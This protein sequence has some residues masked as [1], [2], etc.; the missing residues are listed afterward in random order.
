MPSYRNFLAAL[1]APITPQTELLP[2][3]TF[4]HSLK[5]PQPSLTP[6][7]P[8]HRIVLIEGL[9]THLDLPGW[10]ECADLMDLKIWIEVDLE[11]ARQRLVKR[12]HEAGIVADWDACAD[13]VD[14]VDMK[15]GEAV[16]THR[17]PAD[18]EI[19][20]VQQV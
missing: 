16:R 14:K 3:P 11:V 15:N 8:S 13:R 20:S 5:D 18:L 4:S 6:L 19:V 12:N 17:V 9:Y 7:A 1:T 10:R 2:F